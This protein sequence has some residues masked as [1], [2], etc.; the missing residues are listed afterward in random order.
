MFY[1]HRYEVG[2]VIPRIHGLSA[3][4]GFRHY[5]NT[6]GGDLRLEAALRG[7]RFGPALQVLESIGA[8]THDKE[9]S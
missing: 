7:Q 8:I 3:Y 2:P 4:R 1:I 5:H 6:S 9:H